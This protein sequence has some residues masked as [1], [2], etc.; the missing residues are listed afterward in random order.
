MKKKNG[1]TLT[2]LIGVIVLLGIIAL[3][4]VPILNKTIKNSKEK[5]YNAQVDEI[6][7]SAKKWGVTNN[8][9]LPESKYET[10]V[11]TV[12]ELIEAGFLEEDNILDPR[13]DSS[14][15]SS[16]I[17]VKYDK[18]KGEYSYVFDKA[19]A[20]EE[21]LFAGTAYALVLDNSSD[22]TDSLPLI[23]VRSET[24]IKA[25]DTYNSD[26]Y[27]NIVVKD[28]YTGFET[29]IYEGRSYQDEP[30]FSDHMWGNIGYPLD[31]PWFGY[32]P[33][34]TSV[35]TE[36][37]VRFASMD[38]LFCEMP[39]VSYFNVGKIDL[40]N[41]TS[42]NWT[43]MWAGI[44]WETDDCHLGG[45]CDVWSIGGENVTFEG[46]ENWDVS[47]ITS[48]MGT[49]NESRIN[50]LTGIENWDVSNVVDMSG[51]FGP[52]YA[53]GESFKLD[54]SNWNVDKVVNW[55]NFYY[56]WDDEGPI[57]VPNKFK[58]ES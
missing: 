9:K 41:I 30:N 24:E 28:A 42:L 5:A 22:S 58:T 35:I 32:H 37:Y 13:D 56:T 33:Y 55:D 18:S 20:P 51:L 2:E 10:T 12:T 4:A 44:P 3:I 48:M 7:A 27:G 39:S 45:G 54:L 46:L 49:F 15:S 1:F 29:E 31:T 26:T 6:V 38:S 40:S 17:K 34:I 21:D 52:V 25:G 53:C 23:F 43:F 16:C 14:L 19:C 57:I 11:V 47:N 50:S 36:D 8:Q